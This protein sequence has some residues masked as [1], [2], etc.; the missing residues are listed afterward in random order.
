MPKVLHYMQCMAQ[1][2]VADIIVPHSWMRHVA[3]LLS[4]DV[5][6]D[7]DL[8]TCTE[9][10]TRRLSVAGSAIVEGWGVGC[11]RPRS[12]AHKHTRHPSALQLDSWISPVNGDWVAD[13]D[14]RGKRRL[15][16]DWLIVLPSTL[17][18]CVQGVGVGSL[19]SN[20]VTLA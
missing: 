6:Y 12:W 10:P 19:Q 13:L 8:P 20:K 4:F 11:K 14:G 17:E 2:A 15:R 3:T 18:G 7:A 5:S 16:L 1:V 9:G